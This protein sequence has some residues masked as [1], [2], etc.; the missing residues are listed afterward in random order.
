MIPLVLVSIYSSLPLLLKQYIWIPG[1]DYIDYL[2]HIELFPNFIR[3]YGAIPAKY[4]PFDNFTSLKLYYYSTPVFVFLGL[5][6]TLKEY[7]W[8]APSLAWI[9][10]F[11]IT[12]VILQDM[13]AGTFVGIIGF[14]FIYLILLKASLRTNNPIIQACILATGILFHTLTGVILAISYVTSRKPSIK[15][16]LPLIP[17]AIIGA[18]WGIFFDASTIAFTKFINYDYTDEMTTILFLKQYLGVSALVL[19]VFSI[20]M[21]YNVFKFKLVADRFVLGLIGLVP[22]LIFFSFSPLHLNS[23]RLSKFLVGTLVILAVIGI[24]KSLEEIKRKYPKAEV[25]LT[26]S[27][28]AIVALMLMNTATA[29]LSFWIGLGIYTAP[30]L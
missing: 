30:S 16:Y 23:D 8:W 1:D 24:A 17:L 5:Y 29:Q 26:L 21:V 10:L 6:Y 7:S 19:V 14:Y 3:Y 22:V 20:M 9:A 4:L 18:I 15:A 25:L 13:E 11:F 2:Q 28:I 12:P 27:S